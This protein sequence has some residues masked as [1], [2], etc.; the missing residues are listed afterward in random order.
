MYSTCLENVNQY[1]PASMAA[2][3]VSEDSAEHSDES[4]DFLEAEGEIVLSTFLTVDFKPF[5]FFLAPVGLRKKEGDTI[6]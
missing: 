3:N 5:F 4:D 6:G 1:S 2:V